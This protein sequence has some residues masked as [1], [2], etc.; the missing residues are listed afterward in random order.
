MSQLLLPHY[1]LSKRNKWGRANRNTSVYRVHYRRGKIYTENEP[2]YLPT[3]E[4]IAAVCCEIR[5]GW[6]EVEWR[7]AITGLTEKDEI[8][9]R[10]VRTARIDKL[11]YHR[12]KVAA[13]KIKATDEQSQ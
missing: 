4:E 2:K 1:A 5:K 3:P 7:R 6:G 12:M 10:R 9:G 8:L 11:G 13:S